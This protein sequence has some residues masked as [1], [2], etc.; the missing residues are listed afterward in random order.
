M[1]PQLIQLEQ[2]FDKSILSRIHDPLLDRHEIELWIKR[3]DLL[4][5]VISGNKWR[6]LKYI[7]DHALSLGAHTIIS[8]G[9]AYSN[10]L[11]ALACAGRELGLKTIGLVRGEQPDTLNPTLTDMRHW[12]MEL[13]FVS[14][15]DYRALR[16]YKD[17]QDLPGIKPQQYWL[18]E[19][20]AQALALQGV[21]E[22]V[23]EIDMP[24]DV[25]CVPCGTGTTLAGIVE[26]VP[27]S[28][29][30]IG[31]AA[32]KNASFLT[33]DVESLLSRPHTNW[34][35]N[36]DYHFGGFAQVN[37]ELMNFIA[38]FELK[39][40]IPLEPVYTGKMLYGLYDL[41]AKGYFK[42]GQRIIAVHTGGLQGKRG[43]CQ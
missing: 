31:F 16:Q 30:V 42:P 19:G 38:A 11:H 10:H 4:H 13:K 34:Q 7:L 22:L 6:K 3:D 15:S 26:A 24:Y 23:R 36:L 5:P 2:T 21:A 33:A 17:W 37:A 27:E 35:I 25:L 1:H 9:G 8:M 39:A 32:L 20:G 14:R 28:A 41:I 29:S 40:P 43:F 18:P 12:D